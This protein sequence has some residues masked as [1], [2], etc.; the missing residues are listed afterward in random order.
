VNGKAGILFVALFLSSCVPGVAVKPDSAPV[1][2]ALS[3]KEYPDG[4]RDYLVSAAFD[5]HEVPTRI[6][7]GAVSVLV[8]GD[9]FFR[10]YPAAREQ[11][12]T[13]G[14]GVPHTAAAIRVKSIS[15]GGSDFP[16]LE[17]LRLASAGRGYATL[18]MSA[19]GLRAFALDFPRL[20]L[21][22]GAQAPAAAEPLTLSDDG[23]P[24]VELEAAGEKVRAMVDTGYWRS[25]A[26]PAFIARHPESFE[27]EREDT[28]PD[29]TGHSANRRFFR[30]KELRV[31]GIVF[32]GVE[33]LEDATPIANVGG[34]EVSFTLGAE[35]MAGLRW[36]FDV[37]NR[38]WAVSSS[39]GPS[40]AP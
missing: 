33:V 31:G 16:A 24:V 25:A 2:V 7:T 9:E 27:L 38:K 8:P 22:L 30:L 11:T 21:E 15:L 26:R 3:V 39:A 37:P 35:P 36:L 40:A 5:G 32:R 14:V 28:V 12:I 6:D 1:S 18:G 19:L 17:V 20:R 34:T 29:L 10:G 23:R 13:S 4:A